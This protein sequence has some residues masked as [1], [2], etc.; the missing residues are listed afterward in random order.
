M[1]L[2]Q[3]N[4]VNTTD[5]YYKLIQHN[6]VCAPVVQCTGVLIPAIYKK[7]NIFNRNNEIT[8]SF[9]MVSVWFLIA[10]QLKFTII[11]ISVIIR[12]SLF[13]SREVQT[14]QGTSVREINP[15]LAVRKYARISDLSLIQYP[16]PHSFLL[17][18]FLF[19]ISHPN[20]FLSV[21]HYLTLNANHYLNCTICFYCG[22]RTSLIIVLTEAPHCTAFVS[23]C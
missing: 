22:I 14:C 19:N 15:T 17:R 20:Y 16:I 23:Y 13:R 21:H 8:P 7:V 3:K 5:A 1:K 9:L 6:W 10:Q 12:A 11:R 4:L 2:W 18:L